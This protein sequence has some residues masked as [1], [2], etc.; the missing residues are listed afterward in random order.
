MDAYWFSFPSPRLLRLRGP[1]PSEPYELPSFRFV[2]LFVACHMQPRTNWHPPHLLLEPELR[3][4]E[5]HSRARPHLLR[6]A[7]AA[8]VRRLGLRNHSA[9][10]APEPIAGFAQ[11][12]HRRLPTHPDDSAPAAQRTYS[13]GCQRR[14]LD[15]YIR[16]TSARRYKALFLIQA[17]IFATRRPGQSLG[18][19]LTDLKPM[20]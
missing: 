14:D 12:H 19:R 2:S 15:A 8:P 7:L 20:Y 5:T 4:T 18:F 11:R 3:R 13:A 16:A 1:S 9:R 17:H 6:P 10:F